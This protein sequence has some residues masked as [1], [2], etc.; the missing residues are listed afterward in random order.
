MHDQDERH[1]LTVHPQTKRAPYTLAMWLQ[2]CGVSA[3]RDLVP[4]RVQARS[5][6]SDHSG[7]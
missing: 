4:D 2:L 5:A 6:N 1:E 7:V 3:E